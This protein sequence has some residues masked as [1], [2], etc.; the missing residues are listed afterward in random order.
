VDNLLG[1]H[2]LKTQENARCKKTSLLFSEFMLSA[3]VIPKIS[4][5]HQVHHEVKGVPVL[6]SLTHI[7][8]EFVFE[9]PQQLPLISDRLITLFRQNSK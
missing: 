9:P 5:G 2:K 7:D 3:Y 8:D 4:S 6:K 1:M